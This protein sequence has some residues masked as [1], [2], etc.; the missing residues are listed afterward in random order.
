VPSPAK[1][2]PSP[3]PKGKKSPKPVVE[4]AIVD[5]IDADALILAKLRQDASVVLAGWRRARWASSGSGSTRS[6]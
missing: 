4:S 3:A 5:S 1:T 2:P 6:T